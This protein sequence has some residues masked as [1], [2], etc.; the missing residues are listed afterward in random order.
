M[1]P[2]GLYK[3]LKKWLFD[4]AKPLTFVATLEETLLSRRYI[5]LWIY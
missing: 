2:S 4:F 5:L 1:L 3:S